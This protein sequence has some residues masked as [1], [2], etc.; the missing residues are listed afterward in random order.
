[1]SKIFE[2]KHI[3]ALKLREIRLQKGITYQQLSNE[4][5]LS[6]SYLSEIESGKKYP[7]GDKIVQLAEALDVPYD[8][9]VSLK[10]PKKLQPVI[11][12]IETDFMKEFPLEKFG[13][14][15]QKL[16][17]VVAQDPAKTNAFISTI[18]RIS[19]NYEL[20]Q[21]QFYVAALR[22]YRELHNNY[23]DE[24]EDTV[25]NL[26]LEFT[27]LQEIPFHPDI[28][29]DILLKIGVRTDFEKLSTFKTLK[30][31]RSLYHPKQ[32][33]LYINKGLTKGQKNFLLGREIAFQ[34]LKFKKRPFATPWVGSPDFG[35]ILNNFL[36]SYFSV[37]LIMPKH[38][39]IQDI[40]GFVSNKKW[41]EKSLLSFVDKYDATPEMIIQRFTSILPTY[42]GIQNLFFL[43]FVKSGNKYNLT[44]E[45][46]LASGYTTH[47]NELSEH[48][49]RRWLAIRAI[50]DL[51]RRRGSNGA[52]NL[53]A[54]AQISSF[55]GTD[56]EY[57]GL[58]IA[59]PNISNPEES[60]S[61]T[62]GFLKDKDLERKINFVNDPK[63][64]KLEVNMT[65]ERCPISDCKE[66]IVE[67]KIDHRIKHQQAIMDEIEL[68]M[69]E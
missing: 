9:L 26:H 44:K 35:E 38:N 42:L 63:I 2:L 31:L 57:F 53:I 69:Q 27:E 36:A 16:I 45:L 13:V 61:V 25:E 58:S 19:R 34:W 64:P 12:L 41:N 5:G 4:S 54:N 17:D 59:F 56:S 55:H 50:D 15:P 66:R 52:T 14:S 29:E 48:Y 43:R 32:R 67:P 33:L 23:F 68:L 18:M 6:V 3:F 20:K 39:I 40:R 22:S 1:M 60:I 51:E 11:D 49:C 62:I 28:V 37:A 30:N 46:H 65:C 7:K 8:D 21:E 10:V 24:L 47:A